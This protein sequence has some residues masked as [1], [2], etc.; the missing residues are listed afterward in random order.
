MSNR[1]HGIMILVGAG[2]VLSH[3]EGPALPNQA[4]DPEMGAAS[5]APAI[6]IPQ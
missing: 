1:V 3:V 4:S 2:P 6:Q 5:S